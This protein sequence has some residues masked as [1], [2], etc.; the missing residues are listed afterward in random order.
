MQIILAARDLRK[1]SVHSFILVTFPILFR[2]E[3]VHY[4]SHLCITFIYIH[5]HY[6]IQRPYFVGCVM[7]KSTSL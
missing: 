2:V 5:F 4:V 3:P 1:R 7:L 6:C